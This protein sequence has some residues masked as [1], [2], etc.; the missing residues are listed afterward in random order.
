MPQR[1]EI[2]LNPP[3]KI[4]KSKMGGR[5]VIKVVVEGGD[6]KVTAEENKKPSAPDV[7]EDGYSRTKVYD[8]WE[9]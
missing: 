6:I 7:D 2:S 9:T 8:S 5:K 3:Y 4:K 1:K